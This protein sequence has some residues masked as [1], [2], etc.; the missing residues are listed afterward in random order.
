MILF[1]SITKSLTWQDLDNL[2]FPGQQWDSELW[3][4]NSEVKFITIEAGNPCTVCFKGC[5]VTT[6]AVDN[7]DL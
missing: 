2:W 4:K 6:V 3:K 1:L 5:V 7:T